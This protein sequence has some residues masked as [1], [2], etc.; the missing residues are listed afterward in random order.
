VLR[1][2]CHASDQ[3]YSLAVVSVLKVLLRYTHRTMCTVTTHEFMCVCV[4]GHVSGGSRLH[5][6]TMG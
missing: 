6:H 2:V 4:C 3:S 1:R 5:V